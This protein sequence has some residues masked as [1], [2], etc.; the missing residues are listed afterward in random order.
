MTEA[1]YHKAMNTI[2]RLID[3]SYTLEVRCEELEHENAKLLAPIAELESETDKP[4]PI[5]DHS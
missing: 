1:K 2:T 5:P 4:N 3:Q